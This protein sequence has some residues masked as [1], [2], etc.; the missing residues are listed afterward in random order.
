MDI[1]ES[2]LTLIETNLLDIITILWILWFTVVALG[3]V[4]TTVSSWRKRRT[5][6]RL[7]QRY[8]HARRRRD[9]DAVQFDLD[10]ERI[11]NTLAHREAELRE[12]AE[13][14]GLDF[15]VLG[16]LENFRGR[17]QQR[18]ADLPA[19]HH[20]LEDR[21]RNIY[22]ELNDFKDLCGPDQLALARMALKRGATG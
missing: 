2:I 5:L 11:K 3:L 15:G 8:E 17:I 7:G 12:D 13:R 19:T 4:V 20:E 18:L 10:L 6:A 9:E 1:L 22:A 14:M 21:L 16:V